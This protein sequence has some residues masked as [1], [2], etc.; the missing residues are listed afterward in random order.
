MLCGFAVSF[1]LKKDYYILYI[2]CSVLGN[3][4]VGKGET[5]TEYNGE[6]SVDNGLVMRVHGVFT[7]K[8][9]YIF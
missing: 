3:N 8:E 1:S 9:F 4:W 7:R 6:K 5:L 2:Y